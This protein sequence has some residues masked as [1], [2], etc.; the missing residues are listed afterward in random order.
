[1][2]RLAHQLAVE[3]DRVATDVVEIETV[4]EL[5]ERYRVTSVPRVVIDDSVELVGSQSDTSLL[6]AIEAT[7]SRGNME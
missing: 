6:D 1:M 7:Q 5:A 4:P 2:S 3:S